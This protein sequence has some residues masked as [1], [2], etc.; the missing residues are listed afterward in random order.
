MPPG[1]KNTQNSLTFRLLA[2]KLSPTA[3]ISLTVSI[4]N[5]LAVILA[6]GATRSDEPFSRYSPKTE[7]TEKKKNTLLF[8]ESPVSSF[9]GLSLVLHGSIQSRDLAVGLRNALV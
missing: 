4:G 9:I 7:T 5:F 6:P 2:R 8:E 3:Y 1:V